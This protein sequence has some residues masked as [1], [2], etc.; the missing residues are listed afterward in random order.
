MCTLKISSVAPEFAGHSINPARSP[1]KQQLSV[2]VLC[3][4]SCGAIH[5]DKIASSDM[6]FTLWKL[7]LLIFAPRV[8]SFIRF[9]PVRLW[10]P[11]A[12]HQSIVA[13]TLVPSSNDINLEQAVLR[14]LIPLSEKAVRVL[15]SKR[16]SDDVVAKPLS[17]GCEA[18]VERTIDGKTVFLHIEVADRYQSYPGGLES[19]I[20]DG[21]AFLD[22][23]SIKKRE[24]GVAVAKDIASKL[25]SSGLPSDLWQRWNKVAEDHNQSTLYNAF[26]EYIAHHSAGDIGGPNY[27]PRPGYVGTLP[28]GDSFEESDPIN[29]LPKQVLHPWPAVQQVMSAAVKV[30]VLSFSQFLYSCRSRSPCVYQSRNLWYRLYHSGLH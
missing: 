10:R 18:Y 23:E 25:R 2:V 14:D 12:V 29:A 16:P 6:K 3:Q 1:A 15:T 30:P 9:A 22:V 28:P 5:V 21:F 24:A 13:D 17:T 27:V 26:S 8:V 4:F 11:F 20:S 19:L 7:F